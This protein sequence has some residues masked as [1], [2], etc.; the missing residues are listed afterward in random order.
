MAMDTTLP[1]NFRQSLS[2]TPTMEAE[3]GPVAT[4]R[5]GSASV[6]IYAWFLPLPLP[7]TPASSP[8]PP[9]PPLF[10]AFAQLLRRNL[11]WLD[12]FAMLPT[13]YHNFRDGDALT[14]PAPL[15]AR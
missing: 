9:I 3:P 6:P 12:H 2:G 5:K 11:P 1:P 10:V 4:V 13:P 15:P 7:G 8:N 14:D